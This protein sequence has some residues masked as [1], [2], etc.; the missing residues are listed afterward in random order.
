MN[1]KLKDGRQTLKVIIS[2]IAIK[3]K[4]SN[5]LGK[6]IFTLESQELTFQCRH[7]IVLKYDFFF[8]CIST[9]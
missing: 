7:N 4:S 6:R 2:R 9:S 5:R 3:Q 1:L 8:K